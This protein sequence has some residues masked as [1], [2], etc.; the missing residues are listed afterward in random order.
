MALG[1]NYAW[2]LVSPQNNENEIK[3][4]NGKAFGITNFT[5]LWILIS[6][7]LE[8]KLGLKHFYSKSNMQ[9]KIFIFKHNK[10]NYFYFVK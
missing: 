3:R 9:F 4:G 5:H 2:S 8:K 7:L 1:V 10:Y 6:D